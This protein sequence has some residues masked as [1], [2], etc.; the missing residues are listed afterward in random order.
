MQGE[1]LSSPQR[2]EESPSKMLILCGSQ[3][4]SFSFFSDIANIECNNETHP[5][6]ILPY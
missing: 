2:S 1:I 3:G 6:S 4:I 5:G